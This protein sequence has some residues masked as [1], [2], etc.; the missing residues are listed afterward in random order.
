[1]AGSGTTCVEFIDDDDTDHQCYADAPADE[2]LVLWAGKGHVADQADGCKDDCR[3]VPKAAIDTH[4]GD[5]VPPFPWSGTSELLTKCG[6]NPR[7]DDRTKRFGKYCRYEDSGEE[8]N[9][10]KGWR[11]PIYDPT[12]NGVDPFWARN[13]DKTLLC[14]MGRPSGSVAERGMNLRDPGQRGCHIRV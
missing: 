7:R 10:I 6:L 11:R 14:A 1:M 13:Y 12:T 3:T 2:V 4:R 5:P 8:D 9:P